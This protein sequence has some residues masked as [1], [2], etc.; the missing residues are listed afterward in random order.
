MQ[1]IYIKSRPSVWKNLRNFSFGS[2]DIKMLLSIRI[3]LL[4][5]NIPRIEQQ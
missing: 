5:L 4:K 2:P 1:Y 3:L